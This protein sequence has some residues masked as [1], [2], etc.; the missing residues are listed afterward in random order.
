MN[1][2]GCD[3]SLYQNA[4]STPQVVDFAKMKAAGASFVI[5][6]ASQANWAD[7]DMVLN[8]ANAKRA[9]ILRG[10]YHFLTWDVDPIKQAEYFCQL[11]QYDP[12]ELGLFADFEWW[13]VVPPNALAILDAF[14]SRVEL[15][16]G[17]CGVYTA[18]G[19]W[20]PNG[21]QDPK[22]VKRPLWQA[23]WGVTKPDTMKPWP[24]WTFWQKTN[25]GDGLRYGCESL[26]VDMD[27][28]NGDEVALYKYAGLT[29][30]APNAELLAIGNKL[31]FEG[32]SIAMEGQRICYIAQGNDLK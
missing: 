17:K 19:F 7:R 30:P 20:Q 31:M 1:A 2:L 12:P 15:R 27:E 14:C 6:K 13:G 29:P 26:Q 11:C 10:A 5:I 16:I 22:W 25:K 23:Q 18:P 4:V 8:W 32:Q 9:G 24:T 3:I 21:N 28:F